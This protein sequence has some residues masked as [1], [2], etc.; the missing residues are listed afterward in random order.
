[1]AG[2]VLA[3]L[4]LVL[5]GCASRGRLPVRVL[6][7][8]VLGYDVAVD[9]GRVATVELGTRFELV[10][11]D[12]RARVVR[13]IVL[14][15]PTWDMVSLSLAG[16]R[17]A[18]ASLDGRVRLIDLETGRVRRELRLD[19]AATA[20]VLS[21]DGRWLVHGAESGVLCLRRSVDGALLQCVAAHRARLSALSLCGDTLASAGWDGWVRLWGLPSLAA[22]GEIRRAGPANDVAFS[23]DCRTVAV[24]G[25]AR[26]PRRPPVETDH[27]PV[28]EL[29]PVDGG[30]PLRLVGHRAAVVSVAFAGPGRVVSGAWD[31]TV[32]V[33]DARTGRELARQDGYGHL[34]R[35]V[36]VEDE[37]RALVASWAGADRDGWSV[38]ILD[39]PP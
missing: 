28:V 35:A 26:P 29:W 18:V 39:L 32:R 36:A 19:H 5:G 1:M 13:R 8:G 24:A 23:P 20:V 6:E 7:R 10:V 4:V 27:A 30:P 17:A 2:T 22:V 25:S 21:P 12:R 9:A 15:G 14:A 37:R 16:E 3:A 38:T 31:G 11:R 34:V 33:W